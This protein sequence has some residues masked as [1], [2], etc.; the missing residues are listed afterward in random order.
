MQSA[1]VSDPAELYRDVA[2]MLDASRNLTNRNPGTIAPWLDGLNLSPGASVFHLGCGTGYYS[3]IMAEAVGPKGRLTA[4]EVDPGLPSRARKCL[5]DI[6]N[7]EVIEGDGGALP[8]GRRDAILVHAGVT[9]LTAAWI[10]SL[11]PG[12]TPQSLRRHAHTAGPG[13]W[14]HAPDYCLSTRPSR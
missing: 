12:G 4:V 9:H 11:K 7:V 1:E 10:E 2:V 3:A 5:E 6:D 8:P 13:C 14:L